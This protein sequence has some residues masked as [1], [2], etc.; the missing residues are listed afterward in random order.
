MK[1]AL[2]KGISSASKIRHSNAVPFITTNALKAST[3]YYMIKRG[4]YYSR[5][6]KRNKLK[7]TGVIRKYRGGRK[8]K[9]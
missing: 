1:T 2:L 8:K 7:R 5:M 4:R 3:A 6:R 9:Y